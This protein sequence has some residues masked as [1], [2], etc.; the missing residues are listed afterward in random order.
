MGIF[1]VE[2]KT[3]PLSIKIKVYFPFTNEPCLFLWEDTKTKS[4]KF[5]D[6]ISLTNNTEYYS[7]INKSIDFFKDGI[8]FKV[9]LLKNNS[10][11]FNCDYKN[12]KFIHGSNVL[13]IS[14]NSYTGYSYAARNYVY[15]LINEGY[16]VKWDTR[17]TNSFFYQPQ[18]SYEKIIFDVINNPIKNFD[19][20]IVHHTPESWQSIYQSLYEQNISFDKVYGLTTWETTKLHKK[21]VEYIN[22]SVD[23]VIVPSRFNIE[24]FKNSG[25]NKKINL[26]YHDIFP[27]IKTKVDLETLFKKFYIY[28]NAT[29]FNDSNLIKNI[30]DNN[31]VYYNISQYV[32]R[33]NINQVIHS[34]CKK[35]TKNDDVCL[36]IKTN[37]ERFDEK[38]TDF[39][40]YKFF[41]ILK[42][43]T[44]HP[45]II[46]CFDNL[47]NDE[48]NI[49]HEFS[50]VYFTLN[51][52]EGFGLCTYTAKKI[53]NKIICGKFGAEKEFLDDGDVLINY[54]LQLADELNDFSNYYVDGEQ[55]CAFYDTDY[56][57]SK[58][59]YFP[60]VKKQL[61]NYS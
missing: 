27:F 21:W 49:I 3:D 18:N 22:N 38:E 20:V 46:F 17:F 8:T 54:E 57:V 34:M 35:F 37:L 41:N 45:K 44:N 5:I 39:L 15:Q 51:R 59:K 29:F 60:K 10:V 58:L 11:V 56:V 31:T 2:K 42:N 36:F 52:G 50:D 47:T 1:L 24:S 48:I 30:I 43:Y 9:V 40:K 53:G 55:Q 26:W 33:K 7:G 4:I 13:Y 61:Y 25:V 14:Q 23:E 12:L 32:S 16:N 19:S 28:D 6:K